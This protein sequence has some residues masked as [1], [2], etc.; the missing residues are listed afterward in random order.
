[1]D[2]FRQ[3]SPPTQFLLCERG[4]VTQ[5]LGSTQGPHL[6]SPARTLTL[7]TVGVG[8]AGHLLH[9]DVLAAPRSAIPTAPFIPLPR[10]REEPLHGSSPMA[11]RAANQYKNK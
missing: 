6:R 2:I 11:R 7:R 9:A 10:V 1:M 3:D 4:P 5:R 8:F